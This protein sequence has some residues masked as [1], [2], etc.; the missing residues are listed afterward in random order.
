MDEKEKNQLYHRIL[1][2]ANDA[3]QARIAAKTLINRGNQEDAK[4]FIDYLDSSDPAIRKISRYILGQMGCRDA[5]DPL[6]NQLKLSI[7][8]LTF[9]PDEEFKESHFFSNIIE[10]LESIYGIIRINNIRQENLRQKLLDVFKKTKHEDLRFSLIKL[11]AMLGESGD[12]FL[13]IFKELT[14]KERRA[15]YHI[16]S[17]IESPQR[18][19]IYTMGLKDEINQEF[20]IPNL[21]EFHQGRLML[22][23]SISQMTDKLKVSFLTALLESDGSE[24]LDLLVELLDDE[25]RQV[26]QL[27]I[28][29]IKAI[30]FD[31]FPIERFFEK[32]KTGYSFEM[33]KA[34]LS[35]FEHFVSDK[36]EEY[37]LESLIVQPLYNNKVIILDALLKSLKGKHNVDTEFSKRIL[38]V[39]LEYF[40]GY[41]EDRLDF[42]VKVL[43]VIPGLS[44][45]QSLQ[46]RGIKKDLL[47]F[48]NNH[49]NQLNQTLTNNIQE[50]IARLNQLIGRFEESEEKIKHIEVLFDLE[51]Q[52]IDSQRLEKLKKQL[53]EL[54]E[55]STDF[56]SRFCLFL[57]K[58]LNEASDWKVR[59]ISAE[60]LAEY[61]S[62]EILPSLFQKQ[63]QDQSLGVRV[64]TAK[65]ID[66]IQKRFE[67]AP[68]IAMVIEPLFYVSKLIND[69]LDESG[70]KVDNYKEWPDSSV[71]NNVGYSMIWVSEMF[72]DE[73]HQERLE[74]LKNLFEKRIKR[75]VI[76]TASPEKYAKYRVHS[77]IK[78]LKKPFTKEQLPRFLEGMV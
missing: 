1:Q 44:F 17:F 26:V 65:A 2:N 73:E 45:S 61:G 60:L 14:H 23:S 43:K 68:S 56:V 46:V 63:N 4:K 77:G 67:I 15:L 49:E 48:L 58:L 31:P 37:F 38:K 32:I 40:K 10:I 12:Y 72:F 22:V 41:S 29:N 64:A 78:L 52:V 16:Y 7:G 76:I 69:V 35:V 47:I 8:D 74:F 50:C 5:L 3:K 28:D 20:V 30:D 24:F 13:S 34:A 62:S 59:S 9:L 6:L 42:I 19:N 70:Y 54:S 57:V 39:L 66:H 55:V 11:I 18:M 51:T 71:W 27:A 36:I 33:V 75:V 21:L 53:S 25:N